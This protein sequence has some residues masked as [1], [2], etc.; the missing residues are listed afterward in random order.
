ML[1]KLKMLILI[2]TLYLSAADC[3][4]Q[5]QQAS[6]SF[7]FQGV[8][9]HN[10]SVEE[11]QLLDTLQYKT[12]LYFIHEINP[13]LGLVKDRTASW[14]AISI[15]AMGFALPVYGIGA[16][17]GWISRDE[18]ARITLTMLR[19]LINS[20]Q[21]T[22]KDATGYK[23]FYYHFL[24]FHTGKRTWN[25]ELSTIDT[26][27]LLAGI[28]FARQYFHN[29]CETEKEIRDISEKLIHRV[30]WDFMLIKD[31]GKYHNSVSMGWYPESGFHHM[32]WKGY[33]EALLLYIIAAGTS[34]SDP[35]TTYRSWLESYDWFTPYEG[36]SHAAFPPL[37][38][39]QYTQMFIDLRNIRDEYMREKGIDYFQNSGIAA[40]AQRRYSIE[41][42]LGWKGYDSLVWG[43]TAC[44]GPGEAFNTD[45]QKFLD[46]AG[47]G[48]SGGSHH[49]FDDGTIAPTAAIASLPFAPEIVLP[50]IRHFEAIYGD[51]GLKGKYGYVDAFNPTLNWFND[52]YIAIDQGPIVVMIENY[53]TGFVW[54]Y[55]MQDPVIQQGLNRTGFIP[56]P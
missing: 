14:S 12:F 47:R 28:I 17:K 51:A 55:V 40:H 34:L 32:G 36:L 41:N 54:K 30:A 46:Y 5:T 50:T 33:N 52:D 3:I 15:A 22:A 4:A 26:A 16:E 1:P 25:S 37:F 19:F 11:R 44:D 21:S 35:Q 48:T 31:N 6:I 10:L 43:I 20:E 29:D 24:D 18:A 27:L 23:G 39:H 56:V 42:P 9:K 49:Y 13:E 7:P 38:G 45:T 8:I 53:L 2:I